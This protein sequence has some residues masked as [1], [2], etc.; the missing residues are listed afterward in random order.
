MVHSVLF[1]VGLASVETKQ[2]HLGNEIRDYEGTSRT[3][4]SPC[5]ASS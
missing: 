1:A 4:V 2:R 5:P 3:E